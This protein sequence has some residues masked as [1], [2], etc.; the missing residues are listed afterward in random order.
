VN[1]F[2]LLE[3]SGDWVDPREIVALQPHP[4]GGTT[5]Y[6]RNGLTLAVPTI[7]DRVIQRLQEWREG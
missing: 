7:P 2:E 1:R 3:L 5:V 6:L 4:D